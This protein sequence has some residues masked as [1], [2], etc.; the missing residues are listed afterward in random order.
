MKKKIFIIT[1]EASG[2]KLAASIV[3]FFDQSK[4]DIRAIGS[5]H[6]K[7]KKIKILFDSSELSVMGLWDVFKNIYHLI[8][9]IN[10]TVNFIKKFK[11]EVIFSIDAPDFSFRVE[12]K[13]KK[14][15]PKIK[16]I[17]LVAP[18]IW[19]W[20]ENRAASFKKFIDHMLLLFPFEAPLFNRW[21]I[22][23]TF[24]GHP[25]FEKKIIYKKFPLSKSKKIITL[26]PGSRDSEIKTFM[27]IFL[28]LVKKINDKYGEIFLYH[29]PIQSKHKKIISN[30]F[31]ANNSIITSSE[32]S[33]KNFYIKNSLLSIAKSGTISLDICKNS[34]PL[35]TVYKTSWFN[36][37]LI[38]PFVKVKFGN[39]LNIIAN[40]EIIPEL[41]QGNCIPAS[42]FEITTKFLD[43][44]KFRISNVSNYKKIIKKISKPN[45]SKIIADTIKSYS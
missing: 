2:D 22:K 7:N 28:E 9:R 20:R 34:C 37:L 3:S 17:H 18:T 38:K 1:G 29:V 19:A 33:K 11:P 24:V 31:S 15:F 21:K 13:I 14:I 6:L 41:I 26:C 4:F 23:N 30:Y 5:E 27:P 12:K 44:E 32:E 39:I 35:I 10:H 40:K 8:D 25:F 43:D 16:I 42:I 36:Y 45:T